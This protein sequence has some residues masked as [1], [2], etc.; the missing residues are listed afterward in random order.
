MFKQTMLLTSILALLLLGGGSVFGQVREGPFRLEGGGGG[1]E[2]ERSGGGEGRQGDGREEDVDVEEG[3]IADGVILPGKIDT[4]EQESDNRP[5]DE[6]DPSNDS[7]AESAAGESDSPRPNEPGRPT[8][9]GTPSRV[10]RLGGGSHPE[11]DRDGKSSSR[12]A[13][14]DSNVSTPATL[15]NDRAVPPAAD[16]PTTSPLHALTQLSRPSPQSLRS[17]Q[18]VLKSTLAVGRHVADLGL[19][20]AA[21]NFDASIEQAAEL[22]GQ[23]KSGSAIDAVSFNLAELLLPEAASLERS[24]WA[25]QLS[26]TRSKLEASQQDLQKLQDLVSWADKSSRAAGGIEQIFAELLESDVLVE[27][28]DRISPS[29]PQVEYLDAMQAWRERKGRLKDV[30][31][32]AANAAQKVKEDIGTLKANQR[33]LKDLIEAPRQRSRSRKPSTSQE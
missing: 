30:S 10:T 14:G 32:E 19:E 6:P 33:V 25:E 15:S 9:V 5:A 23:L 26:D 18:R 24:K 29:F 11:S 13:V 28:T 17:I 2:G 22:I 7:P 27:K 3:P 12:A 20:A 31:R 1:G 4:E 16:R 8:E 21:L